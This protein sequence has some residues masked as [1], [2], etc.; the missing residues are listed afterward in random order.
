MHMEALRIDRIEV[1][2]DCPETREAVWGGKVLHLAYA[3]VVA[4]DL[5]IS[6]C[7]LQ[8]NQLWIAFKK[9]YH[10]QKV[11]KLGCWEQCFVQYKI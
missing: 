4:I 6:I 2:P 8:S 11:K 3:Q 1:D 10:A 9:D 5:C 7:L